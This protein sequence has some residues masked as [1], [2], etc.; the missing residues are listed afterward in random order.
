VAF[1]FEDLEG[2]ALGHRT[3]FLHPRQTG[4][5]GKPPVSDLAAVFRRDLVTE[6]LK[7]FEIAPNAMKT[8]TVTA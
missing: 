4:A 8:L 7:S 5:A 2:T 1:A 3:G 6:R